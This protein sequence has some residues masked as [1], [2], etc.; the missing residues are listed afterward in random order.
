M[1][2]K[3]RLNDI[4]TI[5]EIIKS[6]IEEMKTYNN[7]QWGENYPLDE[8]FADDIENGDLYVDDDCGHIKGF[9]CVNFIEPVEYEGLNWSSNDKSMMIH[10]MAVNPRFRQ[11]GVATELINF[12]EKL[13]YYNNVVYLKTDTYSINTKMNSLLK[14]CGFKFIGKINLFDKEKSFYC[15]DKLLKNF[16]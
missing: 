3:A 2:R 4:S 12:A 10:R 13:A 6:T 1:I 8:D 7:T 14:K 9:I 16:K 5:I 15:Y 11:Q